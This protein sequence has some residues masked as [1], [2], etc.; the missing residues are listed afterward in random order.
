MIPRCHLLW[1]GVIWAALGCAAEAAVLSPPPVCPGL[2]WMSV[3][4]GSAVLAVGDSL[5]FTACVGGVVGPACSGKELDGPFEWSSSDSLVARVDSNV[6]H[7]VAPGRAR[8]IARWTGNANFA[9]A[10]E[11]SVKP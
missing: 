4:P 1:S 7:A 2:A 11:V 9:G 6:A 3:T 5:R 10:A 8:I